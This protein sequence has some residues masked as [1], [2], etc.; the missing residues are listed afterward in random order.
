MSEK[1][2]NMDRNMVGIHM[3][4]ILVEYGCNIQ[5]WTIDY[6]RLPFLGVKWPFSKGR[7]R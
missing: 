1:W 4:R 5:P 2:G 7:G 6:I 3:G